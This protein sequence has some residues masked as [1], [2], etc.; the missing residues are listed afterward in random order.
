MGNNCEVKANGHLYEDKS[1]SASQIMDRIVK[2][3][4]QIEKKLISLLNI[5]KD[6]GYN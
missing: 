1:N 2:S 3:Q 5:S 4:K 6:N